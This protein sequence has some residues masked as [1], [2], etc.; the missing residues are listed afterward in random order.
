MTPAPDEVRAEFV[1]RW[2]ER[3]SMSTVLWLWPLCQPIP[4]PSDLQRWMLLMARARELRRAGNHAGAFRM[5]N[6]AERIREH[7]WPVPP[8]GGAM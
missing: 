2:L 1:T 8:S 7:G 4:W 5:I 3:G 6:L